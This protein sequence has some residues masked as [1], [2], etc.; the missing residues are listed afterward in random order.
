VYE[1][2]ENHGKTIGKWGFRMISPKMGL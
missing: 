1:A 2:W